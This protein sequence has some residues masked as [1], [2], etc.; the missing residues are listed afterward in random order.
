MKIEMKKFCL[1]FLAIGLFLTSC[2][3]GEPFITVDPINEENAEVTKSTSYEWPTNSTTLTGR[4]GDD[5]SNGPHRGIDISAVSGT[6]VRAMTSGNVRFAG[7]SPSSWGYGNVVFI[8][9]GDLP[10]SP[11]SDH[12][13]TRY[14]HLSKVLV[15]EGD[16]VNQGDLIGEVGSTGNSTGP[17]LHFE[18]LHCDGICPSSASTSNWGSPDPVDPLGDYF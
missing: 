11:G 10:E 15:E 14:A 7:W 18:V 3:S 4:F 16:W 6:P 1:A 8:H 2:S 5:R 9:H 13:Q 17:H 12:V